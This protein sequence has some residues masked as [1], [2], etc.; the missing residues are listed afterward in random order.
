MTVTYILVTDAE[1][2]DAGVL[3]AEHRE[4]YRLCTT[5]SVILCVVHSAQYSTS[6]SVC[7]IHSAQYST[8]KSVCTVHSVQCTV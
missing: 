8:S 4:L 6:K 7:T 3:K 2:T 1:L 5:E